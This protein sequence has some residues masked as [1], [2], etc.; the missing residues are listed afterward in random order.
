[1]ALHPRRRAAA[2]HPNP[3]HPR[4]VIAVVD[5]RWATR[6]HLARGGVMFPS[7]QQRVIEGRPA[8]AGCSERGG[9]GPDERPGGRA[10]G[11]RLT[12]RCCTRRRWPCGA[13]AGG[14][15]GAGAG[16]RL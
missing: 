6:T 12:R 3:G 16:P 8:L 4:A 1:M 11:R 13:A 7:Q 14:T 15:G 9:R 10:A 2:H 5:A